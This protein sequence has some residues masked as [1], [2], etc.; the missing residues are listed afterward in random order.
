[1]LAAGIARRWPPALAGAIAA[2]GVLAIAIVFFGPLL[3]RLPLGWVHLAAGAVVFF[4]GATWLRKAVLRAAGRKAQRDETAAFVRERERLSGADASAFAT[5]FNGVFA[6]GTEVVV[7]VL[8]FGAGRVDALRA[9]GA[10]A[11]AAIVLVTLAGFAVRAPLARVPENLMKWIVAI[12]LLAFGTLWIGE[13]AGIAWPF[14]DAF[15]IVLAALYALGSFAA[16]A[17][18]RRGSAA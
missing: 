1:V 16:V 8:S 18:L 9:A 2:V 10:G 17:V 12:V 11:L 4:L 14:D 3:A 15:A 5:A 6:E 7:I 13:G